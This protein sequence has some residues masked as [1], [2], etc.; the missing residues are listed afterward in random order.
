[1]ILDELQHP[2]IQAPMAGGP[3]TVA[4]ALAV[5]NAGGMG[6]LATGY[7]RVEVMRAQI[8]ELRSGTEVAFGV[9]VFLPQAADFDEDAVTRY[10]DRLAP[11][12]KRY[13]AKLGPPRNDDDDWQGFLDA[14]EAERPPVVSFTFGCPSAEELARL[15]TVGISTWVTITDPSEGV[16]AQERG[17]DALIV[18]GFEAGGHRGGFSDDGEGEELSVLALLRLTRAACELPLVAAGGIADGESLAAVLVAGASAAQIGSAF[19][20]ADEAATHPAHRARLSAPAPTALT[21]AFS[22]RR[23]RG[24]ANRFQSEHSAHAPRAYPQI[25]YATSPLRARAREQGDA[26]GFNLWAG[27]THALARPLPAAEI[28][29]T[30]SADAA[31]A[32]WRTAAR[33]D[34]N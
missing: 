30:L 21:R 25:H 20:L 1:M 19:M 34:A 6:F 18:Q 9:N 23:A 8:A 12:E 24:I 13:G 11:E 32:V 31:A 5:S 7:G 10:L 22:G 17:A 28:V 26:D 3:S 14:L 27:Q 4:Q 16:I 29:R 15:R 2:I 33:L